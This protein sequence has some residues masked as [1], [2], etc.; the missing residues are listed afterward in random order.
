[1]RTGGGAAAP[2]LPVYAP[3]YDFN[4]NVVD[5]GSESPSPPQSIVYPQPVYGVL[6]PEGVDRVLG[7]HSLGSYANS[8]DEALVE[9]EVALTR[10]GLRTLLPFAQ[11]AGTD[12]PSTPGNAF[13]G[14]SID[15]NANGLLAGGTSALD[16]LAEA[17]SV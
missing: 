8:G 12:T 7:Y 6:L 5:S 15:N 2:L 3:H 1:M 13:A 16:V 14:M 9:P 4:G 17:A 11:G 10:D